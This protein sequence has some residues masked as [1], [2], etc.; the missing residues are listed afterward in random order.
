MK[1]IE[2]CTFKPKLNK[3]NLSYT[4]SKSSYMEPTKVSQIKKIDLSVVSESKL[5]VKL[6]RSI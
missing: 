4:R 5:M 1:R 3:T 6:P 2:E